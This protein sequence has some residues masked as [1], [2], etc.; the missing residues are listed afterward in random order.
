MEFEEFEKLVNEISK[1]IPEEYSKILRDEDIE[2]ICREFV[3][4]G[5]RQEF[6]GKIVFGLFSGISKNKKRTFSVQT[7]PTRIEIYK[8]SFERVFGR[9]INGQMKEQIYRTLVHEIAHY[10]GFNEEEVRERGY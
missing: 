6:P 1:D 7:Q 4:M 5:V 2:I 3:P 10:F 9:E 8:E